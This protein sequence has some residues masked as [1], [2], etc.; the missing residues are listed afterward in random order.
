MEWWWIIKKCWWNLF[1]C[2]TFTQTNTH[3]PTSKYGIMNRMHSFECS[4]FA[5]YHLTTWKINYKATKL[6]QQYLMLLLY[7]AQWIWRKENERIQRKICEK[8]SQFEDTS[9]VT[10]KKTEKQMY[11]RK[12]NFFFS[13]SAMLAAYTIHIHTLSTLGFWLSIL[14][15]TITIFELNNARKHLNIGTLHVKF[16][17]TK[18]MR[19]FINIIFVFA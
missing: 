15:T 10:M 17:Q 9:C 7:C 19:E 12:R 8:N 18:W 2:Q 3:S 11:E 6:A 16:M 1:C 4:L 13:D 5:S 14:P